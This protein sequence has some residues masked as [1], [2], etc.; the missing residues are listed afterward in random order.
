[1]NFL[2]QDVQIIIF[3]FLQPKE[4][5]LFHNSCR[6]FQCILHE[7]SSHIGFVINCQ[8]IINDDIVLWFQKNKIKCNLIQ[9][10]EWTDDG[11]FW[12]Q[13]NKLHR[14]ND[15]PAAIIC[16]GTKKWYQN[17][18]QHRDGDKPAEIWP[19]DTKIWYQ[20]GVIYR[21]GNKPFKTKPCIVNGIKEWFL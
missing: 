10:I 8:S 1:M 7:L 19:D 9:K 11:Q 4:I 16:D 6:I 14:D 2:N 13:N 3:S 12:Y 20:H 15:L 5:I 17:G 18:L 21:D